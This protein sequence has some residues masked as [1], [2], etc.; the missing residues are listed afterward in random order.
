[1]DEHLDVG[2]SGDDGIVL[3]DGI[4]HGGGHEAALGRPQDAKQQWELVECENAAHVKVLHTVF[5]SHH[6]QHFIKRTLTGI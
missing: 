2:G 6:R 5:T 4:Y 1:M 3:E